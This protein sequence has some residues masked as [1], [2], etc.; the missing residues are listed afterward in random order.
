MAPEQSWM[1][2]VRSAGI[3]RLEDVDQTVPESMLIAWQKVR[4]L[5]ARIIRLCCINARTNTSCPTAE[6][7]S[8]DMEVVI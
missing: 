7:G 5:W 1:S 4:Q 6:S 8:F 3:A 2:Y